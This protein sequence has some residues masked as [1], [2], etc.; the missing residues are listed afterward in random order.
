MSLEFCIISGMEGCYMSHKRLWNALRGVL[1]ALALMATSAAC[2]VAAQSTPFVTR[3]DTD[4]RG[5]NVET[6]G[7]QIKLPLSSSGTYNFVVSWGDGSEDRIRAHDQAEVTH[8]Y[9]TR[10]EYEVTITG[11]C[12]GF[13]F[14]YDPNLYPYTGVGD[15]AKLLD[16]SQWGS[17]KLHNEGYQFANCI[18]LSG[19]S[20]PDSPDLS[21]VTDMSNMFH[22][23]VSF[24]QDI[25]SWD[26]SNITDMSSMFHNAESFNQDIGSWNVGNVVDM[27]GMFSGFNGTSSFNQDIGSWNVSNVTDMRGMF[28]SSRS[29]NQDISSWDVS[30]VTDMAGMFAFARSFNQDIS[31]WDVSKVTDM[32][33]M[34]YN[35][36]SFNQDISSWDVSNVTDMSYLFAFAITFNQ[37]ISGWN[38]DRVVDYRYIFANCPIDQ[39]NKPLF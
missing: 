1:I 12:E 30:N 7:N 29:F 20:A 9:A 4:I 18:N 6:A 19:F 39:D 31:S 26:V 27:S 38:V 36:E 3:W 23:A 17:V 37:D 35:A 25:G 14:G 11:I 8:T 21:N 13:G 10:G 22:Y 28:D 5:G 33:G 24:N 2:E 34:F 32:G 15:C 16:V